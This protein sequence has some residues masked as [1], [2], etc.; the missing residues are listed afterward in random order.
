MNE[1]GS[2]SVEHGP[3]EGRLRLWVTDEDVV[4]EIADR[5]TA[6]LP[7]PGMVA[8]TATGVRGRGLWLASELCDVMQV[9]SDGEGTVVRLRMDHE[10]SLDRRAAPSCRARSRPGASVIRPVPEFSASGG[11][12]IGSTATARPRP[13]WS[14]G[15]KT[16]TQPNAGS[17]H[18][19]TPPSGPGQPVPH[20][21]AGGRHAAAERVVE[22]HALERAAVAEVGV[23]LG[24]PGRAGRAG[25]PRSGSDVVAASCSVQSSVAVSPARM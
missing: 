23:A 16:C 9:W 1:I 17:A 3:G 24:G 8:P 11:Q 14:S 15:V 25:R 7:F 4:A 19:S 6:D 10:L 18:S 12:V 13:G 2:N 21:V 20:Q 5:G 22:R